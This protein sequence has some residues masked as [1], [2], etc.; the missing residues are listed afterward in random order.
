M[1]LELLL[2]IRELSIAKCEVRGKSTDSRNLRMA[3]LGRL[4]VPIECLQLRNK[5]AEALS[6]LSQLR[7]R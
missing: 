1:A 5:F 7:A 3:P 4:L 2:K 6:C